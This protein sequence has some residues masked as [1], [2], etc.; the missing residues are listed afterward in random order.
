MSLL[1]ALPTASSW[2]LGPDV[3]RFRVVD[4]RGEPVAGARLLA[5]WDEEQIT[6]ARSDARGRATIT[7]SSRYGQAEIRVMAP[8]HYETQLG[9][10]LPRDCDARGC[11]IGTRDE[12]PILLK[13]VVRPVPMYHYRV[14]ERSPDPS[15]PVGFDLERGDWVAPYGTGRTADLTFWSHCERPARRR[16]AA[17]DRPSVRDAAGRSHGLDAARALAP[18]PIIANGEAG[19]AACHD[20]TCP[21]DPPGAGI[22]D[23]IGS[24]ATRDEDVA[25]RGE[26][27]FEGPGNGL[28]LRPLHDS[29]PPAWLTVRYGLE[30]DP[31]APADGYRPTWIATRPL[32]AAAG[33]P[34]VGYFRIRAR[35]DAEGRV[36][37]G[38]YGKVYDLR[39][40]FPAAPRLTLDYYLNPDG[41]R[42]V[43]FDPA[44]NL[45]RDHTLRH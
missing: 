39:A 11:R 36:V 42:H 33:E 15:R 16:S 44:R 17:T 22:A 38:W 14:H 13:R 34:R 37:G 40:D 12:L 8:D 45:G 27:R 4:D 43:E 2:A 30:S 20:D 35:L 1:L 26:V 41:T 31:L 29:P 9:V 21:P 28:V 5:S 3:L 32:R 24:F 7:G 6:E 10:P 18:R 23:G 19:S 25:C